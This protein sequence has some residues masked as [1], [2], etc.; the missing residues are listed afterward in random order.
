MSSPK[1]WNVFLHRWEMVS[2]TVLENFN[3]TYG[4]LVEQEREEKTQKPE[5]SER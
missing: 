3:P 2:Q 5:M 1:T 4:E